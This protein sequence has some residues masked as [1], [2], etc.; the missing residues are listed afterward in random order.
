MGAR[1]GIESMHGMSG[2]T[3][4]M[5]GLS[6]ILGWD[7]GIEEPCWELSQLDECSISLVQNFRLKIFVPSSWVFVSRNMINRTHL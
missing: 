5:T 6:E 1:F 7:N 2:I 4:G 3:V